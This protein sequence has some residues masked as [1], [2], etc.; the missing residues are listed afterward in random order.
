MSS[1][2]GRL[3][4]R[5]KLIAIILFVAIPVLLISS[6]SQVAFEIRN[7]LTDMRENLTT[8]AHVIAQNSQA[9]LAFD[10]DL[11]ATETLSVLSAM[12]N[13]VGAVLLDLDEK[14][15][16]VFNREEDMVAEILSKMA[17]EIDHYGQGIFNNSDHNHPYHFDMDCLIVTV[18]VML[19]GEIMGTLFIASDLSPLT[20]AVGRTATLASVI[21]LI[22]IL[23]VIW[24]SGW[25]QNY[26]SEP[27]LSLA[28]AMRN[29]G[30]NP[31]YEVTV[32]SKTDDEIGELYAVFNQMLS[33]LK[34]RELK[35][36]EYREDLE[37]K[38]ADRTYAL[39]TSNVELGKARDEAEAGSRAK[40]DFVAM[41]SHEIR[42]PLNGILGMN[43]LMAA[44][45]LTRKQKHFVNVIEDSGKS[46]LVVINDILDFSK[47]EA[48]KLDLDYTYFNLR[49]LVEDLAYLF[50]HQTATKEIELVV[51]FPTDLDVDVYGDEHRIRQIILNLV[52]NAVKF[53][54]AGQV[55]LRVGSSEH[56]GGECKLKF[57]I[58]DSGIGIP[59]AKIQTIQDAFSQADGSTTRK[60]GGTGLGLAIVKR[61][62]N[63]MHSELKVQSEEGR[64]SNFNFQLQAQVRPVTTDIDKLHQEDLAGV[65]VL[66]VDDNSVN[67]E[68]LSHQL[69]SWRMNYRC[70]ESGALALDELSASESEGQPYTL[71]FIDYHMPVMDGLELAKRVRKKWNSE[72]LKMIAL[73]STAE[74]RG[75]VFRDAGI[76]AR[77]EKPARR[78]ELV[79]TMTSLLSSVRNSSSEPPNKSAEET[80]HPQ[81]GARVLIVED[82]AVNQEI[83]RAFLEM[84]G[85]ESSIAINGKECV[86]LF[87]PNKYDLI[88]MDCLMPVMDGFTA[89]KAIREIETRENRPRTPIVA[90]TANALEGYDL[91]CIEAGMDDYLVKPYSSEELLG[92]LL[93]W[94]PDS[95]VDKK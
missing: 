41:M 65:K 68:V 88:L 15:F 8:V 78:D 1:V 85:C 90:L 82:T 54:E 19:D 30:D 52:G 79:G 69:N 5:N 84:Y 74:S 57:E 39:K 26:I 80:H 66:V 22:S 49:D 55:V 6:V 83:S 47:I 46:L 33:E 7:F 2:F 28:G 73:S 77:I 72:K 35:L 38:V 43:E 45:E 18:P 70:V 11:A 17:R 42:T 40:S 71:A 21:L 48:G 9:P 25:L 67:R 20:N 36:R 75:V 64:G 32:T 76:D 3:N 62:L 53:T 93:K 60:F 23:I 16:A 89:T 27:I 44:S 29:L 87:E 95:S 4:I 86:K 13:I 81:L 12:P 92:V 10:D 31:D 58:E 34:K 14:N 91:E 37:Q 50:S 94:L 61:L 56:I 59:A 24:L 63:L 51:D